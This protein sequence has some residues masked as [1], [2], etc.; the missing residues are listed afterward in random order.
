[1]KKQYDIVI[2]TNIPS[3]YKIK[4]YNKL[5][6][7]KKILVIYL[8]NKSKDRNNDFVKGIM[9]FDHLF[10]NEGNYEKRN[11]VVSCIRILRVLKSIRY[12]KILTMSWATVEDFV[13]ALLSPKK[14]N[15][16][17]CESSIYESNLDNWKKYLKKFICSRMSYAYVSGIPHKAIFDKLNFKG[18]IIITGGVGLANRPK[19]KIN[20]NYDK[21]NFKY[22]CVARLTEVKN[23]EFLIEAFNKLEKSLTILGS[24][25]LDKKLKKIANKNIKFEGYIPNEEIH[26]YYRKYDIFILSSKSEPWGLVVEE[27][28]YNGLPVLVSD[29]V[30]SN[31][32]VVKNYNSGEIFKY[33]DFNELENKIDLIE[34]NYEKYKK[35]VE[36]I[37]FNKRDEDQVE[38]YF[39]K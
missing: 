33:N 32:D 18:K 8:S 14:K 25:E 16:L 4:L 24:G 13:I 22:I 38:S 21:N 17:V 12:K 1:M 31:R 10:L 26:E 39:I 30:G 27:A 23:L 5:H 11:K 19:R 2:Y 20:Y 28:L 9:K 3:F 35:N 37:D 36:N 15:G 7:R 29:K 6:E 34:K